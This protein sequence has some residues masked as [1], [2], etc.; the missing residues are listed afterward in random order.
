[1]RNNNAYCRVYDFLKAGIQDCDSVAAE[2]RVT[3]ANG[4]N[5]LT[6]LGSLGLAHIAGWRL[7]ERLR[8][9][10][11][12]QYGPGAH[13]A[14]PSLRKAHLTTE[15][16]TGRFIL[17]AL[18]RPMIVTEVAALVGSAD[19]YIGKALRCMSRDHDS[20]V[21]VHSWIRSIETGGDCKPVYFQ[22]PTRKRNT[23]RLKALSGAQWKALR[24]KRARAA[25]ADAG[26]SEDNVDRI[27][28]AM[29]RSRNDGGAVSVVVEGKTVY[30]RREAKEKEVAHG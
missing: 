10:S 4:H 12:W 23:P 21:Y 17:Q 7:N 11:R 15:T 16:V 29:F 13:V 20:Q 14:K 27:I 30:Q 8:L 9:V 26:Y 19:D 22:S 6:E 5:I 1:M 24:I 28:K 25:Y 3:R 18:T 2:C